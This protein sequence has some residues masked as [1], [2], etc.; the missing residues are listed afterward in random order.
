MLDT[1]D[2]ELT[3]WASAKIKYRY[4]KSSN[5]SVRGILKNELYQVRDNQG[6]HTVYL[7]KGECTCRRWQLSGLPCSHVCAVARV[8]G[9]TSVNNLAKPWFLNKTIKGTYAGLFFLVTDVSTWEIPNEIQ[10]NMVTKKQKSTQ[11][12][13]SSQGNNYQSETHQDGTDEITCNL[14][15]SQPLKGF[16]GVECFELERVIRGQGKWERVWD[17]CRGVLESGL[18]VKTG[19]EV[20]WVLA[21]SGLSC[22]VM[23]TVLKEKIEDD[24]SL[25]PQLSLSCQ[26]LLARF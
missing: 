5:W 25:V 17:S 15:S 2:D 23:V 22:R 24:A 1:P 21:P 13:K 9:L 3:P 18:A 10:Q 8:E 12:A 11:Q 16:Y 7:N 6:I 20:V 19:G 26:F 14:T 4:L